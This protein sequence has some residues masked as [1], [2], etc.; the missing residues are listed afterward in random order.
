MSSWCITNW[1]VSCQYC[2]NW[3]FT[4]SLNFRLLT[5]FTYDK[6]RY[7]ENDANN[8][9]SIHVPQK[10]IFLLWPRQITF[11][12][13]DTR[14]PWC[15]PLMKIRWWIALEAE[16]GKLPFFIQNRP[17]TYCSEKYLPYRNH[18]VTKKVLSNTNWIEILN[19][20]AIYWCLH[21]ISLK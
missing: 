18:C 16:M 10:Y 20:C 2:W 17:N 7:G 12:S 15:T 19:N 14:L 11:N 5:S 3:W 13:S 9:R 21:G 1:F 8:L 4:T 6:I